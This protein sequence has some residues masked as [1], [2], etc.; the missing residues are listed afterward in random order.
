MPTTRR[1]ARWKSGHQRTEA[2]VLSIPLSWRRAL[3]VGFFFVPAA[4]S[5]ALRVARLPPQ[6]AGSTSSRRAERRPAGRDGEIGEAVV[7]L[8]NAALEGPR[9]TASTRGVAAREGRRTAAQRERGTG[10]IGSRARENRRLAGAGRR[11][12]CRGPRVA[13]RRQSHLAHRRVLRWRLRAI[14]KDFNL[15]A[16]RRQDT[17]RRSSRR[18]VRSPALRLKSR[19][20]RRTCRNALNCNRPFW[21]RRHR[22]W[23]RFPRP[24]GSMPRMPRTLRRLTYRRARSPIAAAKWS[25][26]R[27]NRWPISKNLRQDR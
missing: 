2:I 23:R 21:K 8:R 6:I 5:A 18:R 24:C 9:R 19:A 14:R 16:V 7:A 12:D 4:R 3:A 22:R 20:A 11:S 1:E 13:G 17:I 10:E 26:R 15:A 25:A 27:S